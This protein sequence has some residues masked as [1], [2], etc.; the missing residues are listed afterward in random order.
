MLLA[1][2]I[3]LKQSNRLMGELNMTKFQRWHLRNE[4]L[5]ANFQANFIGVT[6][7]KLL[8]LRTEG[9]IP[10]EFFQNPAFK[11]IDAAFAPV[12]FSFV[13]IITLFICEID[14]FIKTMHWVNAGHEPAMIFNQQTGDFS[15]LIGGGLPL[16][17]SEKAT[18][19]QFQRKIEPGEIILLGTDGI[20]ESQSPNGE[21]FGKDR[22]KA[23]IRKHAH[24]SAKVI[25][26]NTI[27]SLDEFEQS[28]QRTDD[29][30]LVVIKIEQ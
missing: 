3:S 13:W 28:H 18:Y 5:A 21:M 7:I 15:E 17:V 29:V 14:R 16:G 23:I 27:G 8:L 9:P 26:D 1:N 20:W 25:L 11:L 10:E 19:Q 12:A 22:F 6:L 4:M 30:T 2:V 24:E